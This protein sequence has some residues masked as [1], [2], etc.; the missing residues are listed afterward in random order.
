M[1]KIEHQLQKLLD[2]DK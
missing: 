1:I 2:I